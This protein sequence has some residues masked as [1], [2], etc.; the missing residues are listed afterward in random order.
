HHLAR[1]RTAFAGATAH[2]WATYAGEIGDLP[3]RTGLEAR[4][5]RATL[6]CLLARIAGRS[7][8]EYLDP[9]ERL[10]QRAATLALMDDPPATVAA[11]AER[12]VQEI[13]TRA[14]G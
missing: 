1:L 2:F 10:R 12:F 5:V 11:L 14:D 13:E 6:G 4:A 8:L 7:P 9:G 3:W